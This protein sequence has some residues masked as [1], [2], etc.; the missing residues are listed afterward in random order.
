VKVAYLSAAL[1]EH[2]AHV[3]YYDR[4]RNGLGGE[5]L[6]EVSASIER[7]VESPVRFPSLYPPTFKRFVMQ[8]FPYR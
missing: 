6:A 5:Y 2:L 8:R 1:E 7:I 4:C 3:E